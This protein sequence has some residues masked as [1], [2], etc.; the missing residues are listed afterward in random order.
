MSWLTTDEMIWSH[1]IKY[2]GMINNPQSFEKKDITYFIKHLLY[3]TQEK[4]VLQITLFNLFIAETLWIWA[5][6][7]R[8]RKQD[9]VNYVL[10]H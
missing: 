9:I 5:S 4:V 8:Q 7:S 10:I 6:K 2:S 3:E 1:A